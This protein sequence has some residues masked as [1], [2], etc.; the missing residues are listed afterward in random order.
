[1]RGHAVVLGASMAGLGAARALAKHYERVTVVD[2][3]VLPR[4]ADNRKGVPQGAHAH[5]LLPSGYRV[6]DEYFPGMMRELIDRGALPTDLTGDFLWYQ[7]GAWK[8]RTDCGLGAVIVTRP[9]LEQKVRER[10]R[11][12]P[13][14]T[15]LEDHDVE[16]AVFDASR[17][18]VTGVQVKPRAGGE[19]R[20]LEAE[21]VVDALGRGSPSPKWLA[22]WG[23]GEVAETSVRI[24][25]GYATGIFERRRGDFH[26]SHGAI[27]AGTAPESTRYAAV[28]GAEGDRWVVTLVG[29]VGDHP[30]TEI[31]A[32]RAFA[33]SLPV[34]DVHDL[35]EGREPLL[36]IASYRFAANRHLHY[37]RLRRFPGRFL[38]VGDAYCSFNPIYGQ[39][40]SVALREARALDDCLAGG[41]DDLARRF[42]A[43]A[44]TII[45]GPWAI[46]T[47]EDFRY[48][49]VEGKRPPGF[50]LVTQYMAR[51]H[52]AATRD[53]VVLRRF[54][55]VASLLAPP[56]AMMAPRIAWRVLV[57]GLGAPQPTPARKSAVM[58]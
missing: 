1:M 26:G 41:G 10:V 39:G 46:A 31:S 7:Y 37:E 11:A 43:E 8:L 28:L 33:A 35:V 19:A 2:R 16:V 47:G 55:D 38:V 3:D 12:L 53:P 57:G 27:I 45:A 54:F 29:S 22:S 6:L 49:Q 32:W 56:T 15:W 4:G 58:A 21:L 25:V 5:G 52:R 36:P 24:D 14:V 13:Q 48:P 44:S 51:A 23:F 40:M 20:T 30:P 18:R 42:F 17:Q 9:L 34:P 50:R